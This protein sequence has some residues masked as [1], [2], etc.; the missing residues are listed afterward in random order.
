MKLLGIAV[1]ALCIVWSPLI[2]SK[3]GAAPL[4]RTDAPT[5][6][7]GAAMTTDQFAW[8]EASSDERALEWVRAQNEHTIQQLKADRRFSQYY[9]SAL[10]ISAGKDV[11]A[12][13]DASSARL[14]DGWIHNLWKDDA[15][16]LGIWRRAK[17]SSFI[18]ETPQ[19]EPLLDLDKLSA[20]DGRRWEFRLPAIE[21]LQSSGRC[22]VSLSEGGRADGVYREFD[23]G[24]REFLGDGFSLPE[25]T[26][27]LVWSDEDTL[28]V[29]TNTD[30][31]E[32]SLR[33]GQPFT[34]VAASKSVRLWRRDQALDD[35]KVIFAAKGGFVAAPMA[36]EDETGER[37]ILICSLDF[38]GRQ[39]YWR[40]RASGELQS[41]TLPPRHSGLYLHRGQ[42]IAR[43]REDWVMSGRTWPAGALVSIAVQGFAGPTPLVRLL[44]TP[45]PREAIYEVAA[46]RSGVLVSS[47]QNVNGRLEKFELK[48]DGW[49]SQPVTVPDH[50]TIRIVAAEPG[51]DL[52]ILSYQSFLQ[53]ITLYVAGSSHSVRAIRSQRPRFDSSRFVTQQ[54]EAVSS[55]GTRIPYFLVRPRDLKH[56]GSAPTLMRGYGGFGLPLYPVYSGVIGRL[57]L[58]QGGVFVLANIR[59]GGEFGPS[60][61]QAAT[62]T[63]RQRSY[64]DFIAV[65][66][67]LIRRKITSPRRLGLE[68]ASNGGLLVGVM[69]NQRPE[70]FHAAVVKVPALDLLRPDLVRGGA[71]MANEYGSLDI[72]E[73]RAFLEKTSPYQNLRN[74]PD[75]P[76]PLLMTARDDDNAHPAHARK[77]AA[78]MQVLG[79]PF[80]FYEAAEGG[81]SASIVPTGKAMKEAI[82]FTYLARTLMD[83]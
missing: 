21:C 69:L 16:P 24:R 48:A 81:H 33:R 27:N 1:L 72:P 4:K 45:A 14:I 46:I 63:N 75:A 59:G 3:D 47:S 28:L 55:D 36:Y 12:A 11:L 5:F 40:W 32:E 31:R 64:D 82:E 52:S 18:A 71:Y 68:G 13:G 76:V 17:L 10:E 6:R 37:L 83:R 9:S 74:H 7:D 38:Q 70:L 2:L 49:H 39:T 26:S 8:L 20:L 54:L 78:K 66:E 23:L 34:S 25:A 57:W 67:D 60:W 80:L 61:H 35:S 51:S 79:M 56:D 53:P 19:W 65:A 73:Q 41:V 42:F 29:A 58:E 77:F 30:G 43:L 44:K 62:K 22:M 15:H 50:G